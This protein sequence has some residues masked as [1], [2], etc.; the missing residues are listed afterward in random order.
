MNYIHIL[1]A[2]DHRTS[3][4]ARD[5]T[6]ATPK[7]TRRGTRKRTHIFFHFL[8]YSTY[9]GPHSTLSFDTNILNGHGSSHL[10]PPLFMSQPLLK[11]KRPRGKPKKKKNMP[12]KYV[13]GPGRGHKTIR[14]NTVSYYL[15]VFF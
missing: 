1:P 11:A 15:F 9:L 2:S 8:F 4:D 13:P 3:V 5:S 12:N 10:T 7:T 6:F 14:G